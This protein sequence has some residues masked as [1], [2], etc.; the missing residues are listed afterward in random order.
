MWHISNLLN[1]VSHKDASYYGLDN[2]KKISKYKVLVED[3]LG[4]LAALEEMMREI[5]GSNLYDF[6][7]IVWEVFGAQHYDSK[8]FRVSEFIKYAKTQCSSTHLKACYNKMVEV[9]Q[10][11]KLLIS[12]SGNTISMW[13]WILIS[14][15]YRL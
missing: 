12:S 2:N 3:G 7:K 1:G 6:I 4:K 5:E 15:V 13:M 14:Q 10:D 9:V 11:D 8:M